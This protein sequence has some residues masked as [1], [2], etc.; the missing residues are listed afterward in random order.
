MTEHSTKKRNF[1]PRALTAA[2]LVIAVGGFAVFQGFG[3]RVG[4]LQRMGSGYFPVLV[5]SAI[6]LLGLGMAALSF[7]YR[8]E[9]E[10]QGQGIAYRSAIFVLGSVVVFG[11]LI[12]SYGM[13][14]AVF[15]TIVVAAFADP[16]Q[17]V[18]P[19]LILA[20]VTSVVSVGLF[21]Y[22]LDLPFKV[23]VW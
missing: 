4:E 6:V 18:I 13:L 2:V 12:D 10:E 16:K 20:A 15:A 17:R 11:M 8:D 19:V 14:P 1:D 3:Y 5:G 23:F 9:D 22:A 21:V 7:L